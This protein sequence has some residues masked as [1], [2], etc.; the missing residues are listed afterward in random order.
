MKALVIGATGLVGSE[1]VKLLLEDEH[2]QNVLVFGRRS[3]G[4][5]HTKLEEHIIDFNNPSGWIHLVKG[6]VLFSTL[7][8]TLS[9]AGSKEAQYQVD[10]TCQYEFAKGASHNEIP[11]YVL[12]SAPS[13]N[14]G[15]RFF[16][17]RMKGEL[18]RD[19]KKL[20]FKSISFIQ[21]G[22]LSGT[23]QIERTGEII[24]FHILTTLNNFGI[25]KK[26]RPIHG[27]TV[28]LAMIHAAHSKYAGINRYEFEE[29]FDLASSE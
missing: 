6:D 10:Y 15:S 25:L 17:T 29:V 22:L 27:K 24:V 7:G 11:V 2:F 1:L 20:N 3:L 9:Q 23:R 12:V 19:V 13:A 18:E 26:Y 8:T 21:P 4:M 14:P 16:Y 28:A 5:A